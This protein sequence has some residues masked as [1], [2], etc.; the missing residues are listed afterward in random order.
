MHKTH[1]FDQENNAKFF[2]NVLP[3]LIYFRPLQET[4]NIFFLAWGPLWMET[5]SESREQICEW[6]PL[7]FNP[8]MPGQLIDEC[9]LDLSYF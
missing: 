2:F 6:L 8:F 3:T 5:D 9:R 7:C 4:N 1:I